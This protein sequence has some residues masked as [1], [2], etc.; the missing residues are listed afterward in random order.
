MFPNGTV[1]T[2]DEV[3]FRDS[4]LGLRFTPREQMNSIA[5]MAGLNIETF[6]SSC[7]MYTVEGQDRCRLYNCIYFQAHYFQKTE[8]H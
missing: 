3:V 4:S 8:H 2:R 6:Y 7:I 5:G 1:L